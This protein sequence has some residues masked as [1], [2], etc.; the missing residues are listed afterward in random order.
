M[1]KTI[2]YKH[3]VS[4]N[5]LSNCLIRCVCK[6]IV[7]VIP[8]FSMVIKKYA[9]SKQ[10]SRKFAKL[11]PPPLQ[12]NFRHCICDAIFII[13]ESQM[14]SKLQFTPT[15]LQITRSKFTSL[16]AD[17]FQLTNM[18]FIISSSAYMKTLTLC[19]Y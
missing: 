13:L 7:F 12:L 3:N 18:Q 9:K 8:Y 4:D 5:Y 16:T 17:T 19:V 15:K 11:P 1:T 6:K 10:I 2:F 14:A